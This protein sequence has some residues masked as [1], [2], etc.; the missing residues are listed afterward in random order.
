MNTV[1]LQIGIVEI[2]LNKQVAHVITILLINIYIVP[3]IYT[4]KKTLS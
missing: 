4:M 2:R 3:H 1:E